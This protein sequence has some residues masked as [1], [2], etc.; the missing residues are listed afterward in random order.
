MDNIIDELKAEAER[1]EWDALYTSKGSFN[2]AML[3]SWTHYS[4]G[5]LAVLCGAI[6]S[7]QFIDTNTTVGA[8]VAVISAALTAII[9]FLKPSDKAEPHHEAGVRFASLKRKARMF[10]NLTVLNGSDSKKLI[11]ELKDIADEYA[12]IQK[13]SPAIPFL[14]YQIARWGTRRGEHVYD[15][16][17][18]K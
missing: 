2:A 10:R 5:S 12:E 9:T 8:V 14:A 16:E 17:D 1:L 18:E 11:D 13:E 4:L 6:A 3:W 15:E 7:K